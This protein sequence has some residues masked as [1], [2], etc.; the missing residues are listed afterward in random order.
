MRVRLTRNNTLICPKVNTVIDVKECLTCEN[1]FGII[2]YSHVNCKLRGKLNEG[3]KHKRIPG[4]KE[5]RN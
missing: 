5:R 1:I 2:R 3:Y 4:N